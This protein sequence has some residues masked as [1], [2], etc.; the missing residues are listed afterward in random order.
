LGDD[1]GASSIGAGCDFIMPE[2]GRPAAVVVFENMAGG[3]LSEKIQNDELTATLMNG[4]I[5]SLVKGLAHLHVHGILHRD[6]Q[7]AS[8]LCTSEGLAKII[9]IGDFGSSSW[10]DDVSHFSGA[11]RG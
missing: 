10:R 11:P 8:V 6:L 1:A 4:T 9:K 3:S 2:E 5:I 7:P